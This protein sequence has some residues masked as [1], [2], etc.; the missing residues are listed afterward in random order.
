[1]AQS[2]EENL[3]IEP[4]I[5][6][7]IVLLVTGTIIRKNLKRRALTRQGQLDSRGVSV[8]S[9]EERVA[10]NRAWA[11]GTIYSKGRAFMLCVWLLAIVWNLTFGA[12]F[13]KSYSNPSIK[14]GGL[15]ALG[16]FAALGIVPIFFALR[17]TLRQLRYGESSCCINGK[18]GVLGKTMSGTIRTKTD[19]PATGDY[20]INLQCVETYRTGTGKNRSTHTNVHWQEEHKVPSSG[21]SSRLGIPFSF[22]LPNYPPETG[23]Q[24]ARGTVTWQLRIDA[25]VEGVDYSAMFAVPVFKMD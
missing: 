19:I 25:P 2:F 10:A 24:L 13:I 22:S 21:K 15:I 7:F 1:M 12:S 3:P 8:P 23:Y 18:A 17:L 4:I 9:I 5:V 11:S 14:T 16:V 20:K 6:G